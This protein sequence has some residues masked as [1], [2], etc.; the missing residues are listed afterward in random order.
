MPLKKFEK[1]FLSEKWQESIKDFD[2]VGSKDNS[3]FEKLNDFL[4][5]RSSEI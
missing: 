1:H 4:K 2:C 5:K 3:N